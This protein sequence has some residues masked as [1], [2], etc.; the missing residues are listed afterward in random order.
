MITKNTA[1]PS[2]PS[3]HKV[4]AIVISY[5]PDKGFL[6]RCQLHLAQFD[7]LV[8]VDNASQAEGRAHVEQASILPRTTVIWNQMNLGIA[9]A[10]NQGIDFARR[11][12]F[13]WVGTFDQ[14]SSIGQD[15]L[16]GLMK[17]ALSAESVG[18]VGLVAPYYI[19]ETTG[20]VTRLAHKY[21]KNSEGIEFGIAVPTITSGNLVPIQTF[22][23]V[24]NFDE[25]LFIDCV[26]Y[27]FCFR[28][29]ARGL[30]VVEAKNVSLNHN[31][32]SITLH[33][34]KARKRPILASNH[35]AFRRYFIARN[36]MIIYHKYFFKHPRWCLHDM[37]VFCMEIIK[38]IFFE[39]DKLKKLVNSLRGLMHGLFRRAGRAPIDLAV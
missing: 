17:V 6:N 37:K 39:D 12:G 22:S 16:S 14:D 33:K 8:I 11:A 5:N 29:A 38:I 7:E 2:S 31:G 18:R 3:F 20:F 4:L 35:S 23:I 10:L 28:C 1:N 19:D 21:Q 26:D 27:D 36:R 15:F 9:A 30:L 32:G 34:I 13:N 25:S 24:G